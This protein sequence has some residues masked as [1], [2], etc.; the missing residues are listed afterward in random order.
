LSVT[1]WGEHEW[2]ARALTR[3]LLFEAMQDQ[4]L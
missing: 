4:K 3:T 2:T 1:L